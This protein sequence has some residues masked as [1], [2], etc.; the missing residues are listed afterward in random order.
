[1]TETINHIILE[2]QWHS[3]TSL[4]FKIPSYSP[5]ATVI[6]KLNNSLQSRFSVARG[7]TVTDLDD[8]CNFC[9]HIDELFNNALIL[10][11]YF[12]YC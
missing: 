7:K 5:G 4:P 2:P 3:E 9:S 10:D 11:L 6:L 8:T 12:D 1:M